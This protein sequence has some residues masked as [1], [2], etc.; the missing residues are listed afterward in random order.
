MAAPSDVPVPSTR[1]IRLLRSPPLIITAGS[2]STAIRKIG[3]RKVDRMNAR[4]RTRSI[5]SRRMTERT[6]FT[7][8]PPLADPRSRP[9]HRPWR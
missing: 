7:P 9:R 8:P 1:A 2:T 5:S 4:V 6:L 3:I